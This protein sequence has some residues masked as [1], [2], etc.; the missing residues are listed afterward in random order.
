MKFVNKSLDVQSG[1]NQVGG[2]GIYKNVRIKK[3][4]NHLLFISTDAHL[5][6]TSP[7]YL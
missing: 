5:K 7:P 3:A 1:W 4:G 2:K 6:L